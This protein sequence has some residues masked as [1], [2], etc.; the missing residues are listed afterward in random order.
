MVVFLTREMGGGRVTSEWRNVSEIKLSQN[1]NTVYLKATG[2]GS[3]IYMLTAYTDKNSPHY[4]L[5]FGLLLEQKGEWELTWNK[6][7]RKGKWLLV[8]H[9]GRKIRI[10]V[11][12]SSEI[13][14]NKL[15]NVYNDV[16]MD[17][18]QSYG[19]YSSAACWRWLK[20]EVI[21][22]ELAMLYSSVYTKSG[23]LFYEEDKTN[24]FRLAVSKYLHLKLPYD[25]AKR[26]T[27]VHD[28][29]YWLGELKSSRE[30]KDCWKHAFSFYEDLKRIS[31]KHP[32]MR[33][34][35]NQL[36]EQVRF[37]TGSSIDFVRII[38]KSL[39]V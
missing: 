24:C 3:H 31:R 30:L 7:T 25:L 29:K 2:G 6:V 28:H 32:K 34:T 26:V 16:K 9:L 14:R 21:N 11:C 15:A 5:H 37:T 1:G 35:I 10:A 17:V 13:A 4:R 12:E 36:A 23:G 20:D 27:T 18:E 22:H 38:V 8:D 19:G 39:E 33:K